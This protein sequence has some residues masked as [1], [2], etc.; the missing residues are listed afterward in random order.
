MTAMAETLT[1]FLG[2]ARSEAAQDAACADRAG[3]AYWSREA[4]GQRSALADRSGERDR[5]RD[6]NAAC[7]RLNEKWVSRDEFCPAGVRHDAG[8]QLDADIAIDRVGIRDRL[9]GEQVPSDVG[10]RDRIGIGHDSRL[11]E[12]GA[13][14]FVNGKIALAIEAVGPQPLLFRQ[15]LRST[16]GRNSESSAVTS[17]GESVRLPGLTVP[18]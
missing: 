8:D 15:F 11:R 4:A 14:G 10:R 7:D 16:S 9:I 6:R 3:Q 5:L 2:D 18:P 17:A 1:F 13:G 12:H